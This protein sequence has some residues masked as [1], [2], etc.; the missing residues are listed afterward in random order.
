MKV[1]GLMA[2]QLSGQGDSWRWAGAVRTLVLAALLGHAALMASAW[3]AAVL[4]SQHGA[5]AERALFAPSHEAMP[6]PDGGA[7]PQPTP[8][9]PHQMPGI[10]P[11]QQAL[12]PLVLLLLLLAVALWWLRAS[13][14]LPDCVRLAWAIPRQPPPLP[15]RQRRALLQVFLN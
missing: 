3:C 15:A 9:A 14:P 2:R 5:A 11:A 10:C 6:A 12:P 7:M 4:G 13:A 1:R 8:Y